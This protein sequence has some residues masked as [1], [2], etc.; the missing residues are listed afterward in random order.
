MKI[1]MRKMQKMEDE[2]CTA[3]IKLSKLNDKIKDHYEEISNKDQVIET[4][5]DEI[6]N[7]KAEI[8]E[9][10]AMTIT[11]LNVENKISKSTDR[12]EIKTRAIISARSK[13][14]GFIQKTFLLEKLIS[15]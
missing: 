7:Y 2:K 5:R 11:Q 8:N 6:K 9:T 3:E 13:V 15:E 14:A 10:K 12:K 4:L 1:I